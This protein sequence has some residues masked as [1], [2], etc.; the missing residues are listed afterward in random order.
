MAATATQTDGI[1]PEQAWL[2]FVHTG[3]GTLAGRW[4]RTFW[5]PVYRSQDLAAGRTMPI[6]IMNKDLTLCRGAGSD[7]HL[8]AFRCAHRGTQLS[9][10]WVEGDD[11]RCFYHGWKYNGSGQCIAQPAEPE[12]FCDKIRV[13]SYPIRDYLGVLFA[14][15][16]EGAER[17]RD[18]TA[19]HVAGIGRQNEPPELMR[20]PRGASTS[21]A[22]R[23]CG[24]R[25]G[26]R[27]STTAACCSTCR[28]MFLRGM[29]PIVDVEPQ[30]LGR[31]DVATIMLRKL[32]SREMRALS[33]GRTLKQWTRPTRVHEPRQ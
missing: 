4:L 16:G 22:T 26:C 17:P 15:L 12:P 19:G 9:T 31:E 25:F 18:P 24:A 21:W 27:T 6:R 2:D 5:Q 8:L 33:E 32:F 30:H 13:R 1:A 29:G 23:S 10:G 20:F 28:T 11:L 7:A 14:Y 3:P